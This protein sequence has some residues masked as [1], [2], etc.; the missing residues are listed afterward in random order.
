MSPSLLR[1]DVRRVPWYDRRACIFHELRP[2]YLS[3]TGTTC[4]VRMRFVA[5]TF[6]LPVALHG[7][8][9]RNLDAP[10]WLKCET[11]WYSKSCPNWDTLAISTAAVFTMNRSII[12]LCGRPPQYAPVACDLD[13][14]PFDLESGVRVTYDV[15]YL[16]ANCS[17]P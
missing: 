15:R 6:P 8:L 17:L 9:S 16:C 4:S 1:Q 5:H 11:L 2:R 13:L 12:K 7:R 14:W 10:T 3:C